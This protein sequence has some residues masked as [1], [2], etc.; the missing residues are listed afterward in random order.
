MRLDEH[1]V[2]NNLSLNKKEAGALIMARKVKV[3][4]TFITKS[5][6]TV[7]EEDVITIVSSSKWVSRGGDKIYPVLKKWEFPVEGKV[8]LDIGAS[9]GGFTDVL[10][11]MNAR[12]VIALD[13]AYGFLHPK[14][15][16]DPRVLSIE[17]K[18]ICDFDELEY[19]KEIDFIVCD[20]SFISLKKILSCLIQNF[21]EKNHQSFEGIFLMKPQFE[22]RKEDTEKG[23]LRK[24]R[25][26]F[27]MQKMNSFFDENHIHQI[28]LSEAGI[29]GRKG[30]QEYFLHLRYSTQIR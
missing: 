27:Y 20:A 18:H 19:L 16:N 26:Q 3:N 5:G 22:A 10:L 9:T 2:R 14:L 12:K 15:R 13:V 24:D 11:A 25:L 30:N 28:N 17:R 29:P 7:K 6:Y 21:A 4:D 23:I 8:F 1:L